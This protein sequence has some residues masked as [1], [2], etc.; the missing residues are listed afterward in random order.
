MTAEYEDGIETLSTSACWTLLRATGIGRLAVWVADHPEIFPINY[1]VDHSS[2][3]F[4]TT[5]G[6]K[7][8]AALSGVPVAL[9]IDGYEASVNRAWSVVVKGRSEQIR[10]V[11]TLTDTLSLPLLP[12]QGGPKG[13]FLRIHP[14]AVSGR[15]F[16]VADPKVWRTPFSEAPRSPVD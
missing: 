7:L 11:E 13:R 3:V 12:W 1:V 16:Q 9:E 10:G 5:E 6:T 14:T 4:R 15:R 8:S 2:L